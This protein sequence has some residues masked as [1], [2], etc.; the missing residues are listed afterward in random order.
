MFCKLSPCSICYQFHSFYLLSAP[1]AQDTCYKRTHI[2]VADQN[3]HIDHCPLVAG[4]AVAVE[5]DIHISVAVARN[6]FS[7]QIPLFATG[8]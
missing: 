4:T 2:V 5:V 1:E 8:K 3:V 6:I 7:D